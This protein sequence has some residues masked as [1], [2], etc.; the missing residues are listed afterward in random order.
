[1]QVTARCTS[2]GKNLVDFYQSTR[3]VK[4]P[5]LLLQLLSNRHSLQQRSWIE[6]FKS[7]RLQLSNVILPAIP[8]LV[9]FCLLTKTIKLETHQYNHADLSWYYNG[10][11]LKSNPN[12]KI[13]ITECISSCTLTEIT[14]EMAGE[15]V[16][17]AT[18]PAGTV[19][20]KAQLHVYGKHKFLAIKMECIKIILIDRSILKIGLFF[21]FDDKC[22]S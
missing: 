3:S 19:S 16:C 17:K 8:N 6:E 11:L 1:M 18:S 13:R 20:T 15:Y 4:K 10:K 9:Y 21:H 5:I 2:S 12:V 7:L 22:F 14:S